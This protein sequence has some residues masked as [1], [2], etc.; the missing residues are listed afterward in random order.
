MRVMVFG[1]FDHLHAGHLYL[2]YHA[3]RKGD[4]LIAII[5][6]DKAVK[7]L[8]GAAPAW[9]EA[10]RR[11]AILATGLADRAILGDREEGSYGVIKR[12]KPDIICLGYDQTRLKNDLSKKMSAPGAGNRLPRI[13]LYTLRP[14][15]AD[16]FHTSIRRKI[17]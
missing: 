5:A 16:V 8:K 11:R 3:K 17:K 6:R 10:K 15:K 12:H 9:N 14:Y 4:E 13:T 7:K 2:L 1:V